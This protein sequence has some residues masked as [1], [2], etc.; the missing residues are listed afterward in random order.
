[1]TTISNFKDYPVP[2]INVGD[3]FKLTCPAHYEGGILPTGLKIFVLGI[4]TKP[5]SKN[6]V[7]ASGKNYYVSTAKY[8]GL[9]STLEQYISTGYIRKDD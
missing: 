8:I 9:W 5:D 1:M 7:S 2:T 3:V 6:R 4:T